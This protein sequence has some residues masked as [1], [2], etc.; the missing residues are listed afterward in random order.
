M[1]ESL[2]K[3]GREAVEHPGPDRAVSEF[4]GRALQMITRLLTN[5]RVGRGN[6]SVELHTKGFGTLAEFGAL[7]EADFDEP[8]GQN[9]DKKA[10]SQ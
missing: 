6:S 9:Q 4:H 5:L 8:A 7:I 10:R 1:V 3:L 2:V